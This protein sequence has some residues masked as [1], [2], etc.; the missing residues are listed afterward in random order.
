MA[1][2]TFRFQGD[3]NDHLPRRWR[4]VEFTYAYSGPQSVKHLIEA[5][6]VPHPE[7]GLILFDGRPV[8]FDHQPAGGGRIEVLPLD[9]ADGDATLRPPLPEPIAFLTD[10]HLGRL[11]R[12]LRLLGLDTAYGGDAPDDLL[13]ERAHDENRVLLTRD[14]GL[15]KRSLVIYGYCLRSTDSREQLVAVLRRYR[16]F[17]RLEPWRRC[18]RCN[19]LL[20]VVE[21][22]AVLHLLEPKTK[23]YYDEFQQCEACGQVYWRGS[24]VGELERLVAEAESARKADVSDTP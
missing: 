6:G 14:R 7:V 20:R 17:N 15:L 9:M 3:L 18:L 4:E 10:N 11:T 2:V 8:G 21:K 16:L 12:Y 5:I 13:A 19:G 24:H 23:L 1:V 22:A